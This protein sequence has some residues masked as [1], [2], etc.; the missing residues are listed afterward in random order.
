[1]SVTDETLAEIRERALAATPGPWEAA[2]EID[3]MRAGQ[4][5]VVKTRAALGE[6][7]QWQARA[8]RHGGSDPPA[9]YWR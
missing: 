9:S 6:N 4:M 5:T 2:E 7:E 8:D 1:M 3:G